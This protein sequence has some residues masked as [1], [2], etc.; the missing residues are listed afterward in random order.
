MSTFSGCGA[1]RERKVKR[2]FTHLSD[3]IKNL[4]VS[5]TA[6]AIVLGYNELVLTGVSS[7]LSQFASYSSDRYS[8][9]PKCLNALSCRIVPTKTA[10]LAKARG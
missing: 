10:A 7:V 4:T 2:S 5:V 6:L 8:S 3:L 1:Q 9:Q